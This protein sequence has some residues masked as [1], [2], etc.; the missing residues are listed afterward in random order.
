[1][2]RENLFLRS[3]PFIRTV[4]TVKLPGK[5]AV[6]NLTYC[7]GWENIH[8]R[9]LLGMSAVETANL[10]GLP[11]NDG[12]VLFVFMKPESNASEPRS[13]ASADD[14]SAKGRWPVESESERALSTA[15]GLLW[16]WPHPCLKGLGEI[17]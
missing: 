4:E 9:L 8:H 12:N 7:F 1:M 3:P 10:E 15:I 2:P 5:K 17:Y 14:V 16:R 6:A 13:E 11:H